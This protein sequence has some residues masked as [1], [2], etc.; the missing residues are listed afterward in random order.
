MASGKPTK[1]TRASA[2]ERSASEP[3]RKRQASPWVLIAAAALLVLVVVGVVLALALTGGSSDDAGG[4]SD[5]DAAATANVKTLPEAGKVRRLYA[6]IPQNGNVL[7]RA[8]APVTM[9]EYADLQCPYCRSFEV[10]SV[11]HL[12]ERYV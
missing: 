8:S 10:E 9:L 11:N 6:G 2:A 5:G 4:S 7:G 3:P 12:V 1:S